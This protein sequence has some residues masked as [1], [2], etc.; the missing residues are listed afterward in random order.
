MRLTAFSPAD[1]QHRPRQRFSKIVQSMA[2]VV[3]TAQNLDRANFP[4]KSKAKDF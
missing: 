3:E 2:I 1:R 4:S